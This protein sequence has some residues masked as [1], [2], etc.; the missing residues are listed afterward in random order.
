LITQYNLLHAGD[1]I[2]VAK[3]SILD[4]SSLTGAKIFN[5]SCQSTNP[6][7]LDSY[8]PPWASGDEGQPVL[9]NLK[10]D[11]EN[12]GAAVH[13]EG[14]VVRNLELRADAS[15]NIDCGIFFY[16]DV[17]YVLLENLRIN[18]Y[19]IGVQCAGSNPP[20]PPNTDTLNEH[21]TLRNSTITNNSN[22]GLL[23]GCSDF[24]IQGNTFDNNGFALAKFNHNIYLGAGQGAHDV[25]VWGNALHHSAVINGKCAGVSLVAHGTWSN[26][27]VAYNRVEEDLG[28]V[29]NGCW[30]ISFDDAYTLA[31]SFRG[32]VIRGNVVINVGNVA[33]GATSCPDCVIENNVIINEQSGFGV[34]GISVPDRVRDADDAKDDNVTIRNNSIYMGSQAQGTGISITYEGSSH[35][36]VSNI[37][38]YEGSSS[39]WACMQTTGLT[40]SSFEAFDYNL[41]YFPN[42]G[43][44]WEATAGALS[45][46]T[47]ATGLDSHSLVA[48]P[49]FSSPGG[50]TYSCVLQSGS[51]AVGTG[52]PT[53]SSPYDI[54]HIKRDDKPDIGA[55]EFVN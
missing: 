38:E 16:N 29:E 1:R 10:L 12:G 26:A 52:H 13:D 46:W 9:H 20:N 36:V 8:T 31:E 15:L 14:Y 42:S 33:I 18:G 30:G 50:P 51:H 54:V 37:I 6:C 40:K 34:T 4:C 28:G 43:G 24:L 49:M 22:Q 19:G 53:L 23:S 2:L 39:S 41:C 47:N 21:I 3:G 25:V 48:S 45:V 11:F 44:S 55:Y 27:L 17:D 35:L 7:V 32:T 5:T